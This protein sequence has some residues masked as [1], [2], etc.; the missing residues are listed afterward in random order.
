MSCSMQKIQSHIPQRHAGQSVQS[1]S[2][3]KHLLLEVE[4]S[5]E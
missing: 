5:V 3:K 2:Y 4:Y 1:V